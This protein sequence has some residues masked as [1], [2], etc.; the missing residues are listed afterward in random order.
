MKL[1][2]I[3]QISAASGFAASAIRYYESVGVLPIPKRRNGRRVYDEAAIDLL[4]AIGVAKAAGFTVAELRILFRGFTKGAAL[5][6]MWKAL[7]QRKLV[8]LDAMIERATAMKDVLRSG[9]ECDCLTLS[10]CR[11]L[12]NSGVRTRRDGR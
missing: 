8:E 7:A 3:G 2:T 10:D 6:R 9:L 12:S 1:L 11:L 5:S 4:R